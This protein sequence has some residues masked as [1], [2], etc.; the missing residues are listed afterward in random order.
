MAVNPA[1]YTPIDTWVPAEY[2]EPIL[3]HI[4]RA[5]RQL[6]GYLR[7]VCI[8]DTFGDNSFMPAEG[9]IYIHTGNFTTCGTNVS[10]FAHYLNCLRHKYKIILS[11]DNENAIGRSV[12]MSANNN[13]YLDGA[14]TLIRGCRIFA[15]STLVNLSIVYKPITMIYDIV[16]SHIPPA[17]ILDTNE[18]GEHVGS[19][20]LLCALEKFP[21]RVCIF[22]GAPAG[23]GALWRHGTLFVNAG[24]YLVDRSDR[25]PTYVKYG[26]PLI[27]DIKI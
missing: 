20:E 6:P 23:H 8:G 15:A 25:Y 18:Y 17:G 24:I 4:G 9:D 26:V 21:P 13:V 10:L 11:G 12:L 16:V 2:T 7:C 14:T 1:K 5:P 19:M 22:G 27:V 3:F